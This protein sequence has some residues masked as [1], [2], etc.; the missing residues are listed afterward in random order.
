MLVAPP[1]SV[2]GSRSGAREAAAIGM[3]L[4]PFR[5]PAVSEDFDAVRLPIDLVEFHTDAADFAV[6][7]RG[8]APS[9]QGSD[10]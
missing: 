10:R 8:Y 1:G 9:N 4:H 6:S 5:D 2:R 7:S 3:G